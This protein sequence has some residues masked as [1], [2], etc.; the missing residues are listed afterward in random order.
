MNERL[1]AISRT[2]KA[3]AGACAFLFLGIGS[4]QATPLA[5]AAVAGQLLFANPPAATNIDELGT[6]SLSQ[7]TGSLQFTASGTPAPSLLAEA[8]LVPFF[9]GR[10]S[11]TLVYQMEILGPP[12][13]VPVSV[14]ASGGVAGTSELLS[15]DPFAGF[16]MKSVWSLEALN[17]GLLISDE[18]IITPA[19]TG[20]FS[21]TWG[22]THDLM[23]TTNSVYRVTMIA[24]AGARGGSAT[25]FVDPVFSFGPG[26]DPTQYA[27]QFSEGIGNSPPLA[28]PEPGGAAM[29]MLGLAALIAVTKSRRMVR[30]DL[31][32]A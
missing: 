1:Q 20:S 4:T 19:L 3:L 26:V 7:F 31:Q 11:G 25:A 14:T 23:L 28:V 18:G 5:P 17:L 9:F 15:G 2:R 10:A 13:D 6:F 24:D 12:G 32:R 16:A 30:G 29:M 8:T 21:Q 27:F 22:E